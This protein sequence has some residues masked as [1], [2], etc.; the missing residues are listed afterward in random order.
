MN[1]S[2]VLVFR[3]LNVSQSVG[4][5][6]LVGASVYFNLQHLGVNEADDDA[7]KSDWDRSRWTQILPEPKIYC[8][9]LLYCTHARQRI[10]QYTLCI[11]CSTTLWGFSC[12]QQCLHFY[13]CSRHTNER[14][15][16][17]TL[18]GITC[19]KN[20]SHLIMLDLRRIGLFSVDVPL[21]FGR[22]FGTIRSA[23]DVDAVV[24]VIARKSAGDDRTLVGQV[25]I[26]V[27]WSELRNYRVIN[28]AVSRTNLPTTA[29]TASLKAVWNNGASPEISHRNCPVVLKSTC[30]NRISVS[31]DLSS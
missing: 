28:Y 31:L 3:P 27:K 4:H 15:K 29:R 8:F 7:G 14:E 19:R 23:V 13:A 1:W 2:V 21:E 9:F 30:S 10:V 24:E 26:N 6:S 11:L 18:I 5:R 12:R 17:L 25:Y 22:R 16:F 20:C